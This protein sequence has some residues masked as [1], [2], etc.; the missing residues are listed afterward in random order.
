LTI[1]NCSGVWTSGDS[2]AGEQTTAITALAR[3][4]ATSNRIGL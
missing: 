3:E 2:S 4:I 1:R